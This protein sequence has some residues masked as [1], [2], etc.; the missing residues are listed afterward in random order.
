VAQ[1]KIIV[2]TLVVAGLATACSSPTSTRQTC[3]DA[4]DEAERVMALGADVTD[5]TAGLMGSTIPDAIEA[6]MLWDVAAMERVTSEIA[7][8]TAEVDEIT[9]ELEASNYPELA[10]AC[11]G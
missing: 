7:A 3:I 1:K 2:A 6:A 8:A 11:R 9:A 4:L 10:E 5:V